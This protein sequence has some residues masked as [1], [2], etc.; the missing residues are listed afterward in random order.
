MEGL[1]HIVSSDD[2]NWLATIPRRVCCSFLLK[3]TSI[4]EV[5]AYLSDHFS[6]RF[7]DE[8]DILVVQITT[9]SPTVVSL[10]HQKFL[11]SKRCKFMPLM[12]FNC[13]FF[14][15]M[16]VLNTDPIQ[17]V[18]PVTESVFFKIGH[19]YKKNMTLI[20]FLKEAKVFS[21]HKF[22][23]GEPTL[24]ITAELLSSTGF[25]MKDAVKF[26]RNFNDNLVRVKYDKVVHASE[27]KKSPILNVCYGPSHSEYVLIFCV[28]DVSANIFSESSAVYLGNF[29][30]LLFFNC[31]IE[32]SKKNVTLRLNNLGKMK[33]IKLADI[34]KLQEGGEIYSSRIIEIEADVKKI[35]EMEK[36]F[37]KYMSE[38]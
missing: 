18:D 4:R 19:H 20:S 26:I 22:V 11:I 36:G 10:E 27:W 16:R 3:S 35:E 9:T 15:E 37:K 17:G 14:P 7:S 30:Y 21:M 33:E 38:N 28:S 5:E 32:Y 24:V 2:E 23:K 6:T 34:K 31:I 29:L 1:T 13:R 8:P 12:V 25:S